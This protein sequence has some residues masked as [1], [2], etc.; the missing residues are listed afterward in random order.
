[1]EIFVSTRDPNMQMAMSVPNKCVNICQ[2]CQQLNT[3]HSW[4]DCKDHFT[5]IQKAL[6]LTD[7]S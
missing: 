3:G 6:F 2:K 1:M 4:S 5:D 7:T